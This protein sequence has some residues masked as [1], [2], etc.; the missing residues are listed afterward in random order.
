M[1]VKGGLECHALTFRR[2]RL[3]HNQHLVPAARFL[4]ELSVPP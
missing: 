4:E 2:E 3:G 1:L